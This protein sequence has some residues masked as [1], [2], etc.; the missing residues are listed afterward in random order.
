M[1]TGPSWSL[2]ALTQAHCGWISLYP[3]CRNVSH[4]VRYVIAEGLAQRGRPT[5][6]RPHS[7]SGDRAGNGTRAFRPEA[8]Y[9][10]AQLTPDPSTGIHK[11]GFKSSPGR[12][13]TATR[14]ARRPP[15]GNQASCANRRSPGSAWTLL[16]NGHYSKETKRPG[17][18]HSGELAVLRDLAECFHA[19]FWPNRT[20]FWPTVLS[21]RLIPNRWVCAVQP[22]SSMVSPPPVFPPS[23]PHSGAFC[24]RPD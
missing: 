3:P 15:L 11:P 18:R 21:A 23:P 19:A 24:F 2:K 4:H 17:G 7:W 8:L 6:M 14:L 16:G 5:C 1:Q 22:P 9:P 20:G 10:T 12:H 13:S